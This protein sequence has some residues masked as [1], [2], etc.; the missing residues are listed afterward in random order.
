MATSPTECMRCNPTDPET[1]SP[2][3][4][5]VESEDELAGILC[6]HCQAV[7]RHSARMAMIRDRLHERRN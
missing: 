5:T 1:G 7:V 4:V 3:F 6:P 2:R